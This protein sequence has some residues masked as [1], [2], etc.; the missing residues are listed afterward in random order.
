VVIG[1]DEDVLP[2]AGPARGR[3]ERIV[4]GQ[5]MPPLAL[6]RQVGQLDAEERRAGNV[7]L[8][9]EIPT[10]FPLVERIR[11]VGEPVLDQ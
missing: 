9:V 4:P 10:R 7:R 2:N 5:R 1:D 6:D 8:E 11:A 3:R